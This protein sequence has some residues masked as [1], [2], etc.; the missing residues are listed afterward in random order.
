LYPDSPSERVF[1]LRVGT[2]RVGRI[3]GFEVELADRSISRDHAV[4][5]IHADDAVVQD[6]QSRNG[7]FVNE[8]R[9][10]RQE[11]LAGDLLRFGE[12]VFRFEEVAAPHPVATAPWETNS[13]SHEEVEPLFQ[14]RAPSE[15]GAINLGPTAA[16]SRPQAKLKILLKV[17]ELLSSPGDLDAVL[18]RVLQLLFQI[19][20]IDRAA[21]LLVDPVSG[22]LT[23]RVQRSR[24]P[25][26][27][28]V[29]FYSTT[30]VRYVWARGTPALFAD[31]QDDARLESNKSIVTN[32]IHGCMCAPLRARSR[33]LGVVYVDNLLIPDRFNGED[34]EFLGAYASQAGIAIDNALLYSRIESEALLRQNLSRFFPP[35]ALARISHLADLEIN[36]AEITA[37]FCDISDFTGLASRMRAREV[38]EVLNV[39]FPAMAGVVFRHEGTLEKYIGDALMAVW[40]TPVTVA[41]HAERAV[42]AALDMQAAMQGVNDRLAARGVRLSIHIGVHSGVAA[43]GNIGSEQYLQYATIGDATNVASRIS[44]EAGPGEVVISAETARRLPAQ[45]WVCTSR[46]PR[47][48]KGKDEPIE[49]LTVARRVETKITT[50][51]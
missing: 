9:V 3:P 43:A 22:E 11:L 50:G 8:L 40:G 13:L 1:P 38:V 20:D 30:V 5:E 51:G 4:I 10:A 23:P 32:S 42:T 49:V 44:G 6:H 48:V 28:E 37:L 36:E 26:D 7:T 33:T 34:L 2:N 31:A 29:A 47:K 25:S 27:G 45:R 14:A 35:T 15:D 16:G 18:G 24:L 19:L 21:I 41:D 39:Y 46:G 17:S 12:L